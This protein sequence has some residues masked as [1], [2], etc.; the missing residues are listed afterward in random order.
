M[1]VTASYRPVKKVL[2]LTNTFL[3]SKG[4]V[5]SDGEP[6]RKTENLEE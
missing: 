5:V 4:V 1:C 2:E 3:Y 6:K